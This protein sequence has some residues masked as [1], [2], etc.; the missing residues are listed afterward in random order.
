MTQNNPKIKEKF[1]FL[2]HEELVNFRY[3]ELVNFR[4]IVGNDNL[5]DSS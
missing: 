4:L 3:E 2:Q 1:N 5:Y